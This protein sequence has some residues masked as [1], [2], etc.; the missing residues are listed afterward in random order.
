[1]APTELAAVQ[2][3]YRIPFE[4][5]PEASALEDTSQGRVEVADDV[6]LELR[7]VAA[8]KSS[9][10]GHQVLQNLIYVSLGY[11]CSHMDLMQG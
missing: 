7:L 1:M 11:M 5:G 2:A 10:M 8:R 3:G 9:Y 6:D 4:A